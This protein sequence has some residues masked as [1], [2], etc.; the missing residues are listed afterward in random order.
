MFSSNYS[1]VG[2]LERCPE[3]RALLLKFHDSQSVTCLCGWHSEGA[4]VGE[5][6]PAL[7]PAIATTMEPSSEAEAVQREFAER[8]A[9][10]RRFCYYLQRF[11]RDDNGEYQPCFVVEGEPGYFP[12]MTAC[13]RSWRAAKRC[14]EVMNAALGLDDADVKAIVESSRAAQAARDELRAAI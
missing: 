12:L 4:L 13:G 9:R 11:M 14:I 1:R 5:V 10:G 8:V 2:A 3:C 6:L 7:A